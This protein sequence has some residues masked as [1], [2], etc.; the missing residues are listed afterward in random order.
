[1]RVH[2]VPKNEILMATETTCQAFTVQVNS[3][4]L[5]SVVQFVDNSFQESELRMPYQEIP[6][7]LIFGGVHFKDALSH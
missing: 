7:A 3:E 2:A 1:M 5:D 4:S 6:T